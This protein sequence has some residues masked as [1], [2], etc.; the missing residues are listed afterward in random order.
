MDYNEAISNLKFISRIKLGEKINVKFMYVQQD[1]IVTKISRTI[2]FE[3]D[4]IHLTLSE[5]QLV[6]ALKL[7]QPILPPNLILNYI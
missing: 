2:Q 4:N 7:L 1:C 3:N 6:E 5:A